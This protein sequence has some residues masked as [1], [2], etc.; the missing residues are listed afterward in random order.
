MQSKGSKRPVF[1]VVP[2]MKGERAGAQAAH[3][4]QGALLR[5]KGHMRRGTSSLG[6]TVLLLGQVSK[7]LV[8]QY[9]FL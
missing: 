7:F 6:A 5:Y 2:G 4:L 3:G 1:L 8:P 9:L